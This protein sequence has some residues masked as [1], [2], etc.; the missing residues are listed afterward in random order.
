MISRELIR[1]FDA[2]YQ[3][4]NATEFSHELLLMVTE[5]SRTEEGQEAEYLQPM[6]RNIYWLSYL[7]RAMQESHEKENV[8]RTVD[9]AVQKLGKKIT[10]KPIY[11]AK[12]TGDDKI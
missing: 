2:F 9:Q 6:M 1:E 7:L 10:A 5:F 8:K 3:T 4:I 11:E 12:L